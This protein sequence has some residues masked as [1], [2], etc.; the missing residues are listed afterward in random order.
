LTL[1]PERSVEEAVIAMNLETVQAAQL[2]RDLAQVA[3]GNRLEIRLV[4]VLEVGLEIVRGPLPAAGHRGS[5]LREAH[6]DLLQ[7]G[8]AHV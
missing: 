7:I 2:V 6:E 4:E 5:V 8:R 1:E 3:L